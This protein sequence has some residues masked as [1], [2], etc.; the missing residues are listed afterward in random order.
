MLTTKF[1]VTCTQ[2]L[3]RFLFQDTVKVSLYYEALCPY[4]HEFIANQLY[5][6][7]ET[8]GDF[9]ELE[10][11][12]YGK[13][14]HKRVH[15]KWQLTCQHGPKECYA[16]KIQACVLGQN[17]TQQE[18]MNF[19][20]CVMSTENPEQNANARKC[21]NK[22]KLSWRTIKT[23]ANGEEGK[24][25]L[26]HFGDI[27]GKLNPPLEYVPHILFNGVY[28]ESTEDAARDDFLKT[29]CNMFNEKPEGC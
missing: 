14:K 28:Q 11:I 19:I 17:Y 13:A 24:Q 3:I 10:L 16:N 4:S 6:G 8:I 15:D 7:Y 27:T 23:C 1:R 9:L 2:L 22:N 26:A 5:P 12:P 21:A 25:L 29:V 20:G 18:S